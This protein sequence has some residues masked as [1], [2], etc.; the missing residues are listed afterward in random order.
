V[1]R[2]HWVAGMFAAGAAGA[3]AQASVGLRR[4]GI[5]GT[6]QPPDLM[7]GPQPRSPFVSA[8]V[9][10]L[11]DLGLVYGRHYVTEVRSTEGR[12]ERLGPLALELSRLSL[13]VIVA[14]GPAVPA[15]QQV[16]RQ[17]PIVM[18]GSADPV[19]QGFVQSLARPGGNITGMSNQSVDTTAK[20]LEILG[21]VARLNAGPVAVLWDRY[22]LL[23]WKEAVAAARERGWRLLSL[24]V[25]EAAQIDEA[26]REA[27]ASRASGL[28]VFNSALMDRQAARIAGL[29]TQARLPAMYGF[30]LYAE[31]GGLLAYGPDLVDNWRRSALHVDKILKGA[32]PA[33]LPVEQPVKF[34]L[35]VNLQAARAMGLVVP[36]SLLLRA[37][38]VI[39]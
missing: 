34:E 1:R 23:N 10:G 36:R 25:R 35:L 28:L 16:V 11:H 4:V 12:P 3:W 6:I 13:D 15:L 9:Q 8:L 5:L 2:R 37:D 29:A 39:G 26:L 30:R 20:R 31:A 27:T 18:T 17:T 38:E 7:G 33:E 24:E 32:N 19:G 21:E 22:S 14:S